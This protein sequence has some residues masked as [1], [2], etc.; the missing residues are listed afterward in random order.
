MKW[1]VLLFMIGTTACSS[2]ADAAPRA[3][4]DGYFELSCEGDRCK[5]KDYAAYACKDGRDMSGFLTQQTTTPSLHERCLPTCYRTE[6][7]APAAGQETSGCATFESYL[8]ER[9]LIGHWGD[10]EMLNPGG[11][12]QNTPASP[13]PDCKFPRAPSPSKWK[14]LQAFAIQHTTAERGDVIFIPPDSA[15]TDDM[16]SP[17]GRKW[18]CVV[19]ENYFHKVERTQNRCGATSQNVVCEASGSASVRALNVIRY[20]LEEAQQLRAAGKAAACQL[21]AKE[22][23]AT[24]RGLPVWRAHK[25][26]ARDWEEGLIYKTHRDGVLSESA[27]FAR[28]AE[29]ATR[30]AAEYEAC[31]GANPATAAADE[32]A[33][34]ACW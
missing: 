17:D 19:V 10:P 24:A 5:P 22:A 16:Q 1:T 11:F 33:F 8:C 30:A 21:A 27:L 15:W 29:Y 6:P 4:W 25:Q 14:K 34:H 18:R 2:P 9:Q 20:R 7:P 32:Q 28:V 23:L 3:D 12:G 31:G 13:V 26:A